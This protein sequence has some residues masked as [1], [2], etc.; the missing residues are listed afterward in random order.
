MGRPR[1]SPDLAVPGASWGW[2]W[3]RRQ[4]GWCSDEG[5]SRDLIPG[6]PWGWQ[7][8]AEAVGSARGTLMLPRE[9]DG[10]RVGSRRQELA[11]PGITLIPPAALLRRRISESLICFSC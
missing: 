8:P 5:S 3:S 1:W 9:R 10:R 6:L 7:L 4:R 11:A 2:D